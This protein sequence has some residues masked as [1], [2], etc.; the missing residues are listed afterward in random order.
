MIELS[1][2]GYW[3]QT[4]PRRRWLLLLGVNLVFVS[5]FKG[6]KLKLTLV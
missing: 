1:F 3:F 4:K 5:R 6:G 2:A